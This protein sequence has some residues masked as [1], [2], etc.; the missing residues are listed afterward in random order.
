MIGPRAAAVAAM[1]GLLA[2][3]GAAAAEQVVVRA[4]EHGRFGR[5]AFIWPAPVRYQARLDG[6]TLTIHFARPMTAKLD[7]IPKRLHRYVSFV[8]MKDSATVMAR[9]AHGAALT[10]FVSGNT[11]A[12]DIALKRRRADS[13]AA[14]TLAEVAPPPQLI[15]PAAG[16]PPQEAAET[17]TEKAPEKT[18]EPPAE[19]PAAGPPTPLVSGGLPVHAATVPLGV[20]LRFDWPQPTA[21]AVFRR[22]GALWI[23]FA[24]A[25]P[26]DLAELRSLGGG[27]ISATEEIANDNAT[28]LRLVVR[29]GIGAAVTRKEN[30]W[31]VDLKAQDLRPEASISVQP[32]GSAAPPNVFF[33]AHEAAEPIRLQDPE[34][35][36]TL[37][38]VPAGEPGGIA[39]EQHFVDFHALVTAQGIAI[40]PRVDDLRLVHAPGGIDVTRDGGLL[41]SAP[42]ERPPIRAADGLGRLLDFA[43]WAGPRDEP[44]LQQRSRLERAVAAAPATDR[45]NQRLAL[46]RFYFANSYAAEAAGVIEAIRRDDPAAITDPSVALMTGAV[47]LMIGDKTAAAQDLTRSNLDDQP[48]AMLWRASLAAETGDWP[49]AA[50]GFVAGMDMLPL[51]PHALR[52]H[53]ALQAAEALIETGSADAAEPVLRLVL[54]GD[55][56]PADKAAALYLDGRRAQAQNDIKRALERWQEVAGMDDRRSRARALFSRTLALLDTNQITRAEAIKTLDGLRFA[57]RGDVIEFNLLRRLGELKLAD[58]DNAGGFDALREAAVNFPDYA[59]AKDAMKELSDGFAT[60]MLGD[61]VKTMSPIRALSLYDEFKDFAPVGERGDV[62]TRQL[63][64]RLVAVDLLDRAASVLEDEVT[65]RLSGRDKARGATQLALLRLLGH[66]P[67]GALKALAIDIGRDLPAEL[68]RRRQQLR[69]RALLELDRRDEALAIIADD[70]SHDADRLRADIFWRGRNWREAAKALSRLAPTPGADAELDKEGSQ[71]VLDWASALTLA[72]DRP[73]V[74]TLRQTYGKAM[75]ATAY[76]DAF[77]IIAGDPASGGDGD[78]R[79]IA[80]RVAQVSELQSFMSGLKQQFAKDRSVPTN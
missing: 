6:T 8:R 21:A 62:I 64:D 60:V 18:A 51:Y 59:A 49:E 63:V 16:A 11:V 79:A 12:V 29:Q 54:E 27:A 13:V 38:V 72:G 55:P 25:A 76:G 39:A 44:F 40:E 67:D 31:I 73:G 5:I 75:G 1:L 78:P 14:P 7:T 70:S 45:T 9:V 15:E 37:L 10:S 43:S 52:D 2:P 66:N 58:G 47:E 26:L 71:L 24:G 56:A 68:L 23:V 33:A 22:G 30:S 61:A 4:T 46:A 35:G 42:V 48:E 20:T 32:H 57:W 3:A 80:S 36:D 50:H 17:S 77:R 69:A 19:K 53:F 34:V 41:L 65:H 28:V 74:A